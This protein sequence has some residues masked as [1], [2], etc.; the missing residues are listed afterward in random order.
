[1]SR[2]RRPD[3]TCSHLGWKGNRSND[4]RLEL[5]ERKQSQ[6]LGVLNILRCPGK[7]II[8]IAVHP[9]VGIEMELVSGLCDAHAALLL[10]I[11]KTKGAILRYE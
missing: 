5:E 11:G 9:V 3:C 6:R 1:V 4:I 8:C 10:S 7:H 2:H